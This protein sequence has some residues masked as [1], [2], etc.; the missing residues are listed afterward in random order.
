MKVDWRKLETLIA[1]FLKGEGV[2][3]EN[4]DGSVQA[5]IHRDDEEFFGLEGQFSITK[6]SQEI[7]DELERQK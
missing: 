3:V 1:E 7:A 2:A 5:V 6:L 4:L